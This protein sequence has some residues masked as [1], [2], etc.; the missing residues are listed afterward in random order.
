MAAIF[1]MSS[2]TGS[3]LGTLF[4][5]AER[6]PAWMGGLN[7]GHLVAYYVLGLFVWWGIGNNRPSAKWLTVIICALYGVTDEWHQLYVDGR[8]AEWIDLLNDTIGAVLAMLTLS[9]PPV[10]R[11]LKRRTMG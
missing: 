2:R 3:E 7:F 1:W 6:L 5:F 4:P 11:L 8:S 9:I 10:R